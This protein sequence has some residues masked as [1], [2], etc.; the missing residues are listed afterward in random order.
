MSEADDRLGRSDAAVIDVGSNSV[1]LVLYRLEGR[2]IWSVFNEKVLA[3]LGSQLAR[4]GRLSSTGRATAL[5]ALSRFG[6]LIRASR[7]RRVFVAATAAVRDAE[8]GPDFAAQA[9]AACGFPLRILS[10][11]DEARYAALGVLAGAPNARGLVGDLGGSSLELTPLGASG[12]D[13]GVT[14]PLGPFAMPGRF[15][16]AAVRMAALRCLEPIRSRLS[17]DT[18]HAVG[19]AWRN[20]ALLHMRMQRYPLEVVHQY[21]MGRRDIF[22]ATRMISQAPKAALERID[23]VSRRRLDSLPHAAVVLETLAE[24]L[25]IQRVV[26][27][28]HGVREGLV[29]ESLSADVR[30][31]DPLI[32]GC[33]SLSARPAV[34]E[35]LGEALYDWLGEGF[36][37]LGPL[38]GDRDEILL[39]AACRLAEYGSQMHPDHRADLVFNQVLRAPL[40]GLNHV[41]RAFLACAAFSRYTAAAQTPAPALIERLLSPARW[42]RARALGAAMRTACDLSGRS[43]ELLARTR[44]HVAQDAVVLEADAEWMPLLL[45][46]QAAKRGQALAT[47]LDRKMR[48]QAQP[49]PQT[50]TLAG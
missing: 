28:A 9:E 39:A 14:L 2:M 12:P 32:V 44:F 22:E 29:W 5:S 1:R 16:A 33:A 25:D 41:E 7:P 8:D 10:G 27:S 18:L 20:L 37:S 21:E 17:A 13:P 38:F 46:E 34:A 50:L 30:D 15:D 4:T 3:G 31:L 48:F 49:A 43:P 45:G 24:R 47:L 11:E 6:A 35:S 19:G 36:R 26:I 40:S 23:G 42:Q